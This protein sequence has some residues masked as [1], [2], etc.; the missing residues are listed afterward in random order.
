M[1]I[2]A[3][4]V[5]DSLSTRLWFLLA[6]LGLDVAMTPFT[7]DMMFMGQNESQR[8]YQR[9]L[10]LSVISKSKAL[11]SL[12]WKHVSFYGI[13]LPV[14]LMSELEFNGISTAGHIRGICYILNKEYSDIESFQIEVT[15]KSR[16]DYKYGLDTVWNC[17]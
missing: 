3:N 6:P 2:S 9:Q 10:T 8:L 13:K 12:P 16:N 1:L 14:L 17:Q 15:P 7:S 4:P 11:K 5:W